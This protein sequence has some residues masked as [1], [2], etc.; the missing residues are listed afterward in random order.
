MGHVNPDLMG[1][2][3]FEPTGHKARDGVFGVAKALFQFP[4]GDGLAPPVGADNGHFLPCVGGAVEIG[5]NR[6]RG[7][8]RFAPDKGLIRPF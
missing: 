2:A 8:I 6:A 1:A 3:G 4:M 5:F 7:A